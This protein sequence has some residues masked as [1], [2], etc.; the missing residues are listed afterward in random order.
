MEL[1]RRAKDNFLTV[2]IVIL[3]L[4]LGFCYMRADSLDDY[5]NDDYGGPI[6]ALEILRQVVP[7]NV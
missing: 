1:E 6:G 5:L 7:Y 3:L 4:M 2:G